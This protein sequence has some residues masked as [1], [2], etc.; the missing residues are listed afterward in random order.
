[1]AH[2]RC[3]SS[4]VSLAAMAR[5]CEGVEVVTHQAID[6]GETPRPTTR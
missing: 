1:M 6:H 4:R 5:F 2:E 3:P